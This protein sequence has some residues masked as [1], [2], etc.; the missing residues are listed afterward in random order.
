[1]LLMVELRMSN[2]KEHLIATWYAES[3]QTALGGYHMILLISLKQR[4]KLCLIVDNAG[5]QRMSKWI[6]RIVCKSE[7]KSMQT[8][9]GRY[10][11][12]RRSFQLAAFTLSFQVY[13][14]RAC[15]VEKLLHSDLLMLLFESVSVEAYDIYSQLNT[16]SGIFRCCT[17]MSQ[18]CLWV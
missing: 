12:F 9:Q 11:G 7:V 2:M 13:I 8:Y 14:R 6:I 3:H 10:L 1:M 18:A 5:S 16:R 4:S 15:M 17:S